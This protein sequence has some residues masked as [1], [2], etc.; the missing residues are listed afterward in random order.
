MSRSENLSNDILS[1]ET[2]ALEETNEEELTKRKK[3]GDKAKRTKNGNVI[4]KRMLEIPFDIIGFVLPF[5]SVMI[6][7]IWVVV[8]TVKFY[9]G[10]GVVAGVD[11][12]GELDLIGAMLP[13]GW[14]SLYGKGIVLFICAVIAIECVFMMASIFRKENWLKK[15]L[16]LL[17]IIIGLVVLSISLGLAGKFGFGLKIAKYLGISSFRKTAVLGGAIFV[18]YSMIVLMF[19]DGFKYLYYVMMVPAYCF[20]V[21][22]FASVLI[23][24]MP[25]SFSWVT[26]IIMIVM[27]ALML[28]LLSMGYYRQKAA[29]ASYS[30]KKVRKEKKQKASADDEISDSDI[31][32]A[33]DETGERVAFAAAAGVDDNYS[34]I[35]FEDK[36]DKEAL[37]SAAEIGSDDEKA[38]EPVASNE[39]KETEPLD[40]SEKEEVESQESVD[41]ATQ[42]EAKKTNHFKEKCLV[43]AVAVKA[44]LIRC[45]EKCGI[46]FAKA[47]Q[48]IKE[49]TKALVSNIKEKLNNKEK[50]KT[51]DACEATDKNNE[52]KQLFEF[53]EIEF[54][55]IKEKKRK[56]P[57]EYMKEALKSNEEKISEGGKTEK[58][59]ENSSSSQQGEEKPKSLKDKLASGWGNLKN[60]FKSKTDADDEDDADTSVKKKYEEEARTEALENWFEFDE[61]YAEDKD[62]TETKES[63]SLTDSEEKGGTTNTYK[64]KKHNSYKGT[65]KNG[66]MYKSPNSKGRKAK[67][68]K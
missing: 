68:K 36:E 56:T 10:G 24:T 14:I 2:E 15:T 37:S 53:D 16:F 43:C 5:I 26:I 19:C 35:D 20:V 18:M 48:W 1:K 52:E 21:L 40:V 55:E 6:A 30:Q 67:K 64:K 50:Q 9:I 41:E 29:V 34:F 22:P 12:S 38:S 31:S 63:S 57:A 54:D 66:G 3:S 47:F 8:D 11:E 13:D 65:K 58:S 4:V 7:F 23:K 46:F 51:T 61:D 60:N 32:K 44:F 59:A 42:D 25:K 62:A 27:L 28:I 39:E 49:K 33:I 45:K 17:A